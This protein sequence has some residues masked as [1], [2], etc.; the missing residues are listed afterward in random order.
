MYKYLCLC[1]YLPYVPN[2]SNQVKYCRVRVDLFQLSQWRINSKIARTVVMYV[3]HWN[4]WATARTNKTLNGEQPFGMNYS[5]QAAHK[6]YSKGW[7]QSFT[8]CSFLS[9]GIFLTFFYR[10]WL[11]DTFHIFYRVW[12]AFLSPFLLWKHPNLN[13]EFMS[14][15]DSDNGTQ[16]LGI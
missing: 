3:L 9:F 16:S 2:T 1:M 10:S 4:H 6:T 11:F 15:S 12:E 14:H 7:A 8:T 5:N 13:S